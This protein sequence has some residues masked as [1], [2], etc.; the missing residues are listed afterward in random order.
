[1]T[2]PGGP[3]LAAGSRLAAPINQ[4]ICQGGFLAALDITGDPDE[5]FATY[6][7]QID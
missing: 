2:G 4:P 3:T 1:M 7:E 5:V 6:V